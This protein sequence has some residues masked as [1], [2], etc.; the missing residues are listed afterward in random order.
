LKISEEEVVLEK[1]GLD[2]IVVQIHFGISSSFTPSLI[3]VNSP[4]DNESLWGACGDLKMG[5]KVSRH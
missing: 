5:A 3:L 1:L 4:F 2:V